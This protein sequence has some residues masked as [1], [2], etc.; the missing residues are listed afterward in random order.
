MNYQSV[1]SEATKTL[2]NHLIKNP[3]L[4]CEILLSNALKIEREK[5]LV[6]LNQEINGKDLNK[7][8]DLINR[9]KKKRTYSIYY[10]LQGI[11]EKKI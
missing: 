6:N 3:K 8:N 5:L 10:W 4:D 11:L 7:F 1:L 2:K 9:R